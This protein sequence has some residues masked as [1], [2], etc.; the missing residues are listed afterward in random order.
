MDS[1]S[2]QQPMVALDDLDQEKFEVRELQANLM[3]AERFIESLKEKINK[4]REKRRELCDQI[5]QEDSKHI[6][7]EQ[8]SQTLKEKKKECEKLARNNTVQKH[9]MESIMM[10]M[11]KE[12][13]DR[14]KNEEKLAQSLKEKFEECVEL[15]MDSFSWN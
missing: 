11:T 7:D 10:R 14:K 3:N 5:K 8:L 2:L 15:L 1:R 4:S 13:E 6:V 9:E 12:I